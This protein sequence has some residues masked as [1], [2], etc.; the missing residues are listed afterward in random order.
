MG[1]IKLDLYIVRNEIHGPYATANGVRTWDKATT[2][3]SNIGVVGV[4]VYAN[5]ACAIGKGHS[6]ELEVVGAKPTFHLPVVCSGVPAIRP[7]GVFEV[8]NI[9]KPP[10]HFFHK[11]YERSVNL[12]HQDRYI[13]WAN[14]AARIDDL[15]LRI[16]NHL[17]DLRHR[18]PS[19]LT[20]MARKPSCDG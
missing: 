7:C 9:L 15:V 1:V 11:R 18:L 13:A 19:K 8:V 4:L 6:P 2:S 5:H 17:P 3:W 14:T 16:R 12:F 20:S 10:A